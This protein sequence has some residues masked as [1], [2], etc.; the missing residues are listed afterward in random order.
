[1]SADVTARGAVSAERLRWRRS[2]AGRLP[3]IGGVAACVEGLLYLAGS[4]RQDWNALTHWQILWVT[5]LGPVSAGLMAGLLGRRERTAR[6]GGA[7][8]RPIAPTRAYLAQFAVLA[9]HAAVLQVFVLAAALQFGWLGGLSFPGPVGALAVLAVAGWGATLVLLAVAHHVALRYGL[10]AAVGL[11]LAWAVAG[12]LTA[13]RAT[14]WLQPWAWTVRAAL[15]LVGT[16][17]NGIPVAPGDPLSA[18]SPWPPVLLTVALAVPVVWLGGRLSPHRGGGRS[19]RR[20]APVPTVPTGRPWRGG[21]ARALAVSLR[22]TAV[23]PL[24]GA[25]ALLLVFS[26][27]L[28]GSPRAS[29]QLLGLG[30]L[31]AGTALLPV[32]VWQ[33]NAPAWRSLALR[34]AGPRRLAIVL[35]GLMG[36]AVAALVCFTVPVLVLGGMPVGQALAVGLLAAVVAGMLVCWH[37]WLV[38]RFGVG[39]TVGAGAVGLLA[40][41]VVGGSSLAYTLWPVAPW[42]WAATGV[43][44]HRILVCVPVSLLL[45]G[46]LVPACRSAARRAAAAGD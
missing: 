20:A 14:W 39:V 43:D 46:I 38:V 1:M 32:L 31:P 36:A 16:H 45:T 24:L 15:P 41:V 26:L 7:W 37:F 19:G 29:V 27:L 6:G 35:L 13:E 28:W 11:G 30:V 3:L 8:W 34:V 2:A 18:A 22:R 17:A 23:T 21:A 12:T 9:G 5:G 44:G 40:A 10:F 33:A 25:T 4:T 42:A